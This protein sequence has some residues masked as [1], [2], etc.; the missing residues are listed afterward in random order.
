MIYTKISKTIEPIVGESAVDDI[1][2]G[3]I[4]LELDKNEIFL[5]FD[6]TKDSLDGL[7]ALGKSFIH[8]AKVNRMAL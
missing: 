6:L 1:R 3:G 7:E 8:I 2:Q 5:E 4:L